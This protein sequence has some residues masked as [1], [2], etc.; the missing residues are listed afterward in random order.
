MNSELSASWMNRSGSSVS[1]S[2]LQLTSG[3]GVPEASQMSVVGWPDE[4]KTSGA[5]TFK[6]GAICVCVCVCVCVRAVCVCVYVHV[7]GLLIAVGYSTALLDSHLYA[8][9]LC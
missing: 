5:P 7:S 6:T 1:P 3:A 2:L 9:L 4:V 8:V